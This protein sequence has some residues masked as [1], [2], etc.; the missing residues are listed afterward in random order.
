M[1]KP[2]TSALF[3][4]SHPYRPGDVLTV[5]GRRAVVVRAE[6]RWLT[7]AW[8]TAWYWRAIYWLREWWQL[9]LVVPLLLAVSFWMWRAFILWIVRS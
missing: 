3:V 7:I 5:G 9:L 1:R 4:S 8:R 6:T 2:G